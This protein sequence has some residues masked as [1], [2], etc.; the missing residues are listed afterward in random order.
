[1]W[2]SDSSSRKSD[3]EYEIKEY[4]IREIWAAFQRALHGYLK[5]ETAFSVQAPPVI[6]AKTRNPGGFR[7]GIFLS[8]GRTGKVFSWLM[9]WMYQ[10]YSVGGVLKCTFQNG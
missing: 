2:W 8:G 7:A 3:I 10:S 1:M 4:G 5:I 9:D 6:E